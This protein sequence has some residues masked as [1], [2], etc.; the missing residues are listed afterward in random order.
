VDLDW[1]PSISVVDG[2][3]VYRSTM[4]GGPYIKLNQGLVPTTN[5]ADSTAQRGRSYFYVITAVDSFN[6][7]SGHSNEARTDIPQ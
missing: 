5:Y 7:E 3:N 6:V 2:Y 4:S 1:D